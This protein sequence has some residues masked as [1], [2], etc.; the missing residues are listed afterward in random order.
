MA[1]AHSDERLNQRVTSSEADLEQIRERPT[2]WLADRDEVDAA[3]G[4]SV[5]AVSRP[6]SS[7]MSNI[8]ALFDA[9]WTPNG[10]REPQSA[11]LVA[12]MCPQDDAFPVFPRYDLATQFDV[13]RVVGESTELPVPRVRWLEQDPAVLGTP[14]LV[15]DRAPRAGPG[16]QSPVRF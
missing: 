16:R 14:F 6:E 7:G 15:M 9:T 2:A 1:Q 8:S 4:V 5:S 10:S 13:M 11:Q 12:R 3:A